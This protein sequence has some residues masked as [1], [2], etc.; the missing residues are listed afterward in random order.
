M[1]GRRKLKAVKLFQ[2]ILCAG[3]RVWIGRGGGV[4]ILLRIM[5]ILGKW[6]QCNCDSEDDSDG[7]FTDVVDA[8]SGEVSEDERAVGGRGW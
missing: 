8:Y 2:G 3:K 6:G 5:R 4:R 7:D 1:W